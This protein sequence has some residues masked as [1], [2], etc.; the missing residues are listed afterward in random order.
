MPGSTIVSPDFRLWCRTAEG[1]S[2]VVPCGMAMLGGARLAHF[3][4]RFKPF[5]A[6]CSGGDFSLSNFEGFFLLLPT[7]IRR[8][9]T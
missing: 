2:G 4:P 9:I 3:L 8:R 7:P 1:H 6:S 5:Q